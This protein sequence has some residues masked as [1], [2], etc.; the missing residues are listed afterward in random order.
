M[1]ECIGTDQPIYYTG[2]CT[3]SKIISPHQKIR[4][5]FVNLNIGNRY[6]FDMSGTNNVQIFYSDDNFV[7]QYNEYSTRAFIAVKTEFCELNYLTINLYDADRNLL[8]TRS[9]GVSCESAEGKN[10]TDCKGSSVFFIGEPENRNLC[11]YFTEDCQKII[12]VTPTPTPTYTSTPTNTVSSTPTQTPTATPT[13][14]QTTTITSTP[15]QTTSNT[16]TPTVTSTNTPTPTITTTPTTTTTVTSS[17]T[18]TNTPTPS[19]VNRCAM[20]RYLIVRLASTDYLKYSNLSGSYRS[21]IMTG[22][23][24]QLVIDNISVTNGDLILVKNNINGSTWDGSD[25]YLVQNSGSQFAPWVL[26]SYVPT[27]GEWCSL[28]SDSFTGTQDQY[29]PVFIQQGLINLKTEWLLPSSFPTQG[30]IQSDLRCLDDIIL[31][32]VRIATINNIALTGL[33]VIDGIQTAIN[34]RILVKN[35]TNSVD[36]GIY[37][38]TGSG[39]AWYRSPDA[40]DNL[41]VL[42]ELRVYISQGSVNKDTVWTIS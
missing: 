16:P 32:Q 10:I 25:V 37:I 8:K 4:I 34:D 14:S 31:R 33:P 6:F 17:A 2:C 24:T 7:A 38:I 27:T 26:V 11:F 36:N 28:F 13:N 12:N 42:T 29:C 15:S 40:R 30:A 19:L 18:A 21:S 39:K 9:V 1:D 20:R 23:R 41:N 3:N 5:V 22:Y 35:Q